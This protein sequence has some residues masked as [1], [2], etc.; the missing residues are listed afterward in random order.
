VIGFADYVLAAEDLAKRFRSQATQPDPVHFFP[1][2]KGNGGFRSLCMPSVK[3]LVLIRAAVGYMAIACERALSELPNVYSARLARGVPDWRF[4]GEGYPRFRKDAAKRAKRWG[5][6]LM[7]RTDVKAYYPSIPAGQLAQDLMRIGCRYG[8][9]SF[10]LERVL[11]WQHHDGLT[12]IPVGPEAC[13]VPGTVYLKPVDVAMLQSTD[14]YVRY[15]DDIV[16][17]V[18][19]RTAGDLLA[20]LDESLAERGL[21]RGVDKTEVHHDQAAA[22]EAIERR[23]F[24][25]LANGLSNRSPVVMR[26][27][28]RE[29]M[30]DVVEEMGNARDFRWYIKVFSNRGDPFAL[31]WLTADWK[32]FNVDPRV[33]ADYISRCGLGD[34]EVVGRAIEKLASVPS[35]E[36]AGA[37]LHLLR[38]FSQASMGTD[39]GHTFERV[40]NDPTRPSQVRCWAWSAAAAAAGFNVEATA[41]AAVEEPDPA[42]RRGMVLSMRGKS[43]RGTTWALRDIA[44]KHPETAPAC[45]WALVA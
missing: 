25:S 18:A 2:P 3:D 44:R 1:Y 7:V 8:P 31:R 23:L 28:K 6:E 41:E 34:S 39:E 35:D 15:T 16:Y 9:T 45:A 29:F 27:V 13:G 32:R 30:H 26:A 43:G 19:E 20:T 37:D 11:H 40:A 14:G 21:R 33:S 12:G 22:L 10:F 38:A 42:I 24:A 36:M 17:F 5:C 4:R